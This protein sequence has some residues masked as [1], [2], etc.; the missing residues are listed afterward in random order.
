VPFSDLLGKRARTASGVEVS[1]PTVRSFFRALEVFGG[2]VGAV[3]AAARKIDGRLSIDQ[4]AAVFLLDEDTKR[5]AYVLEGLAP[6]AYYLHAARV[7]EVARV[8]AEMV[9]PLASRIDRFLG[10][11]D[12]AIED[13]DDIDVDGAILYVL[14]TAE[15]LHIDPMV[16]LDWPLGV[17]LDVTWA[18]SRPAKKD[19]PLRAIRKY[20]E[21]RPQVPIVGGATPAP[22]QVS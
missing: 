7:H 14:G 12:A 6:E 1:A 9:A 20:A 18:F 8:V 21:D 10:D 11:P 16:I 4:A 13:E 2:E 17:F 15:R 3:R 22:E 5:L 19:D